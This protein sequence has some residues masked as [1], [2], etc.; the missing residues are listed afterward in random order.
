MLEIIRQEKSVLK[1]SEMIRTKP[2]GM[3]NQADFVNGA[4]LL[5]TELSF[6]DFRMYLKNLEDRLGRDRSLPKFGP[7]TMD[8]DII[9]W[10]DEITDNDYHTR[11]FL[12]KL[13]PELG[14]R[15]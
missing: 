6:E 13:G 4:M 15:I 11:D 9:V 12:R 3:T 10:N 5:E 8:L 7:R 14:F 1:V 2:I